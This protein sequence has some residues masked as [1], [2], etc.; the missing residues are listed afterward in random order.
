MKVKKGMTL[1]KFDIYA[2]A[3][4]TAVVGYLVYRAIK[5]IKK[6]KE[7]RQQTTDVKQA[8]KAGQKLSYTLTSYNQLA[9]QIFGAWYSNNSWNPWNQTN[10]DLIISVMKKMKNDL[11]VIQLIKAFGKR[12]QPLAFVSLMSGDVE[13]G[14]WLGLALE[15]EEMDAINRD[16]SNKGIRFQ[17]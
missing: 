11:D 15:P 17:F 13:L 16:F 6:G 9:D 10:G 4:G 2:I 14:Q 7:R 8:E 1:S 5:G 12:R 3:G